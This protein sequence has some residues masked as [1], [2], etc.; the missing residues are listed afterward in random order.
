MR[1]SLI[2]TDY[3]FDHKMSKAREDSLPALWTAMKS[4]SLPRNAV[5]AAYAP[6]PDR[7]SGAV[8]VQADLQ[9]LRR[10]TAWCLESVLC[11]TGPGVTNVA[12]LIAGGRTHFPTVRIRETSTEWSTDAARG[13]VAVQSCTM[14]EIEGVIAPQND[15]SQRG[16]HRWEPE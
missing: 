16:V 1:T 10:G 2:L 4:E 15:S 3:H 5:I 9:D 8:T 13:G 7:R 12:G 6:S 14:A 11:M